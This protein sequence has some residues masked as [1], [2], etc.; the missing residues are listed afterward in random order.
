MDSKL[1]YFYLVVCCLLFQLIQAQE[2]ELS[3][4]VTDEGMPLPYVTVLIQGTQQGTQTDLEGKYSIKPKKGDTLVFSFIGMKDV[5]YKTNGSLVFNVQMTAKEEMLNEVVVT[6]LG[7][8]RD[9]KK[10]GYSSQEVKGENLSSAGQTNAVNALSGN[11]AGL[12]VTAPSS[13]GGS[14]RIVLRGVK[15]VVGNNQPLIVIDGVP[16]DNNNIGD[17]KNATRCRRS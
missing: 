11:V 13:M 3:G 9:K 4:V 15:S 10:L 16:L 2:K 12:Q 5:V 17:E 7:I 14:T 6:A 1:R 8:K